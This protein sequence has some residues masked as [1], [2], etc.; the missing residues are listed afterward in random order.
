MRRTSASMGT[1]MGWSGTLRTGGAI[2]ARRT[3]GPR[4]T[5]IAHRPIIPHGT[6]TRRTVV[7]HRAVITRAVVAHGT[8]ITRT[9]VPN[10]TIITHRTVTTGR[11][12]GT[13][14]A[15]AALQ[16]QC[17]GIATR[18]TV[19][20]FGLAA[21]TVGAIAAVLRILGAAAGG[22]GLGQL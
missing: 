8:I 13:L 10:R 9:V 22:G 18:A 7:A 19:A 12:R 14:G 17:I 5:V 1:S 15:F 21:A 11:T 4:R 16:D 3:V 2:I 6:V 20:A